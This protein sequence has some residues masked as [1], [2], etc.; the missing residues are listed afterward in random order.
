MGRSSK[1]GSKS[2]QRESAPLSQSLTQKK[3]N[4]F[5]RFSNPA[6]QSESSSEDEDDKARSDASISSDSRAA[7]QRPKKKKPK[8][9]R[10]TES[11]KKPKGWKPKVLPNSASR[12]G[13]SS[14]SSSD[15]DCRRQRQLP[16][17]KTPRGLARAKK[18]ASYDASQV[19]HADAR[20]GGS[21]R[22]RRRLGQDSGSTKRLYAVPNHR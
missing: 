15:E 13:Y 21:L 20:K 2:H 1:R 3:T 19:S 6:P 9:K 4:I 5:Q 17:A 11:Q 12:S 14:S 10:P 16:M 22:E 8:K 7:L 18:P